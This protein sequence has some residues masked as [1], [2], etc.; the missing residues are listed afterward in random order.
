MAWAVLACNFFPAPF[1]NTGQQYLEEGSVT[2]SPRNTISRISWRVLS[3]CSVCGFGLCCPFLETSLVSSG[4][5][6]LD[7][8]PLT[9]QQRA[10]GESSF[11]V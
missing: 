6:G 1:H 11:L 4:H 9:L 5:L 3:S 2:P 8:T 10:A 7:L